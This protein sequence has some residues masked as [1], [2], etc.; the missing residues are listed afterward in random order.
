M[1]GVTK[2][3]SSCNVEKS[4]SIDFSIAAVGDGFFGGSITA[5]SQVQVSSKD[6]F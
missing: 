3:G 4:I 1:A 2:L 5:P 6:I